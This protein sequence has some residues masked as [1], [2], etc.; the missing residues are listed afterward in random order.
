MTKERVSQE[1][2]VTLVLENQSTQ[3]T[4]LTECKRKIV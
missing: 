2:K 1:Y 3:L 4:V